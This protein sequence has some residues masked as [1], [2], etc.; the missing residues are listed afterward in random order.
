VEA[1][2]QATAVRPLPQVHLARVL[3]DVDR[4]TGSTHTRGAQPRNPDCP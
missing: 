1:L 4:D 3:I 2:A